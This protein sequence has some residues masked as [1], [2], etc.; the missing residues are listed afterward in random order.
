MSIIVSAVMLVLISGIGVVIATRMLKR[1]SREILQHVLTLHHNTRRFPVVADAV[2]DILDAERLDADHLGAGNLGAGRS[3]LDLDRHDS[4]N[5]FRE[6]DGCSLR[7]ND[8]PEGV[9]T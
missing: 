8:R 1:T 4:R 5:L 9:P 2:V 3:N 6:V 7:R